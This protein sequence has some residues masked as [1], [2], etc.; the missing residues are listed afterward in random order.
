MLQKTNLGLDK[1]ISQILAYEDGV[2]L[3]NDDIRSTGRN[4]DV[5]LNACKCIGLALNTEEWGSKW[6]W[7][8]IMA[9][10]QM[11]ISLSLY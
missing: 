9:W 8:V 1:D 11:S 7:G 10:L 5:L 4:S 6:K 3:T 2:N